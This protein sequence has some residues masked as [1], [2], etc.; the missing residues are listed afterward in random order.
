MN[1]LFAGVRCCNWA[2]TIPSWA[3]DWAKNW[4]GPSPI[5]GPAQYRRA[6]KLNSNPSLGDFEPQGTRFDVPVGMT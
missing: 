3:S 4:V 6:L 2:N 5:T 1:W